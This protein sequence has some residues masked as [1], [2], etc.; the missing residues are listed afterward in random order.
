MPA[1]LETATQHHRAGRLSD[2]E[3]GCRAVLARDPN[4]ADALHL[5]GVVAHESGR[6]ADAIVLISRAIAIQGEAPAYHCDLAAACRAA[7]DPAAALPHYAKAIDL[8]PTAE[9][10]NNLGR[11]L[12][13][14]DRPADARAMY[15]RAIT[16]EPDHAEAQLNLGLVALL[17]GDFEAGWRGYEW[18]WRVPQSGTPQCPP[19][20]PRWDGGDPAGLTI[21]VHCEQRYGDCIQF[22]RYLPLLSGRG[23]DVVLTCPRPL[24]RLFDSLPDVCVVAEG[25]PTPRADSRVAIASLPMVFQTTPATI[26]IFT[27]YLRADNHLAAAWKDRLRPL[28]ADG[29]RLV[30]LA[31][32]GTPARAEDPRRSPHLNDFAPLATVP[33]VRFISLQEGPASP[34][35]SAPPGGLK[36]IDF[37]EHVRDFADTAALAAQLDLVIA[38]DTSVAPLAGAIGKTTWTL[39]P[40][41]ADWRW[42]RSGTDTP[43]YPN[44]RLFRQAAFGDWSPAI[45]DV[46]HALKPPARAAA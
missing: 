40:Y 15:E 3:A 19:D 22:A 33:G 24:A 31:W 13:M 32:D 10:F 35:P 43:W 9:A 4:D 25:D 30:G 11:A 14:L 41:A 34:Q 12:E 46:V 44:M 28:R 38:T 2:A 26:P 45:K 6:H 36:L 39:V 37:S 29:R 1:S 16:L 8:R 20:L 5:L 23:A 7:G 17:L 21:L 27:A 42:G 18:R